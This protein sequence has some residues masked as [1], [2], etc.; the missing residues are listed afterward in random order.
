MPASSVVFLRL[1]FRINKRIN[2][3]TPLLTIPTKV[4]AENGEMVAAGQKKI[5]DMGIT[6]PE[7][8]G[9]SRP[10]EVE[11]EATNRAIGIAKFTNAPLYVVHV[12]GPS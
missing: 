10:V 4:H 2:S 3:L 11:I 1:V 5:F 12:W 7:G 6:G 8:H 9:M